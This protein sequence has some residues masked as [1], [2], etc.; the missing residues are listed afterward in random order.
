[1]VG[2]DGSEGSW[3][4]VYDEGFEV[5]TFFSRAHTY[6]TR[7]QTLAHTQRY[8]HIYPCFFQVRLGSKN[9]FAFSRYRCKGHAVDLAAGEEDPMCFVNSGAHENED[10]LVRAL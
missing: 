6:A 8:T 5:I 2:A 7:A 3:T 1:V 9:F 4:P 10:G